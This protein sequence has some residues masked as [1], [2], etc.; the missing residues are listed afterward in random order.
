MRILIVDDSEFFHPQIEAFLTTGGY[1]DLT[2]ATSAEQALALLD[3]ARDDA[4]GP[5]FDLVLMDFLMPGM[6]G[7][8][9]IRRIKSDPVNLDL[10]VMV[11]TSDT[12]PETL[13]TAFEAG[14]VDHITKPINPMELVTRVRSILRIKS[15]SDRRKAQEAKLTA[16]NEAL[17][18]THRRVTREM[19][20][21]GRI[22]AALLPRES[23]L[24]PGL[25]VDALYRPSGQ[26]SGDY[27]DYIPL[28]GGGVRLVMADVSGHG[29]GAAV[30]MA[31]MRTLFRVSR[32]H[33]L[34]ETF[35]LINQHLLE[36][37]GERPDYV[38]VLAADLD[39][40]AGTLTWINA[41]HPPG[42]LSTGSGELCR[43]DASSPPLGIQ[44]LD[45]TA[46]TESV[47]QGNLLLYTDG[48]YEFRTGPKQW[49]CLEP[50]ILLAEQLMDR[51]HSPLG[52]LERRI[53]DLVVRGY[54]KPSGQEPEGNEVR[55]ESLYN[56]D[57]T[58][59]WASWRPAPDDDKD[60]SR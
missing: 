35:G 16:L 29:A 45:F 59:L 58:A 44:T 39:I 43:L 60:P 55:G 25:T 15:E 50:F 41:G 1:T 57:Q 26:A 19:D 11:I 3:M 54:V 31:I 7:M 37:I 42:L 21:A 12:S 34:A 32:A 46:K 38:S 30:L 5:G 40:E 33:D 51:E 56:D 28:E 53:H 24:V 10:P 47:P 8:E 22:Q 20:V 48:F 27:Y 36:T 52:E 2:F 17:A 18:A 4:G 13:R 49:F 23:P 9:A 6:D 14:A